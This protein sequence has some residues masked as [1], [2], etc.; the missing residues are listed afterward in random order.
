MPS[1]AIFLDPSH[2]VHPRDVLSIQSPSH[3]ATLCPEL[4]Y[5]ILNDCLSGATLSTDAPGSFPWYLG[6]ICQSWR[7]VF[8]SSP[9]FWDH[10][11]FQ[12]RRQTETSLLQRV[13]ALVELCIERTKDRPFSFKF[14]QVT[15]YANIV[16][17]SPI[18]DTL[19]AHADRWHAA[20]L[21]AN[22]D[23]LEKSLTKA[24]GR[25]GRLHSLQIDHWGYTTRGRRTP[26]P[27][28]VFQDAPNLTRVWA[29]NHY[30]LPWSTLA[31]LHADASYRFLE[32]L[33]KMMCLEEL[34]ISGFDFRHNVANT[35]PIELPSLRMLSVDH[36]PPGLHIKTPVLE[37]LYLG[38]ALHAGS[39]TAITLLLGVCNLK[40]L[41][42]F[43]VTNV[44]NAQ[45]IEC[46]P[47][48]D[49]LI[50]SCY[51]IISLEAFQSLLPS[52]TTHSTAYSLTRISIG[53]GYP[54]DPADPDPDPDPSLSLLHLLST[55]IKSWGKHQFPLRFVSVHV[56][57]RVLH[58]P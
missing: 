48:L 57:D 44:H 29:D 25:F 23:A 21:R 36:F 28:D 10:F 42:S 31:V 7:S 32:N 27:S 33:D 43:Y 47:Q 40:T 45:I 16:Q 26:P 35:S 14:I 52:L 49:H 22:G 55:I 4:I 39:P 19:V 50:L 38:G 41:S 9:R 54:P 20:C 12:F 56:N 1:K 2:Q 37:R 11:S 46:T 17:L 34:V 30:Q 6:H 8:V 18:L 58:L 5:E 13:Q 24:K 15:M 3:W 51:D 53:V